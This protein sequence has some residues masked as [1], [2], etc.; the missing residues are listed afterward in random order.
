[1]V[2]NMNSPKITVFMA[3][4]NAEAFIAEAIS[5]ILNQSFEDFE[6][7]IVNDGSTDKT[8]E[9]IFSFTDSR[10]RLIHNQKNKGLAYTRNRALEEAQGE[11]IAVLDSD[12]IAVPDRLRLQYD[13]MAQHPDIAL[14]GGHAT[15]IDDQGQLTGQRFIVPTGNAV[16]M[17]MFFGNPFINSAAMFKTADLKEFDGYREFVPAEDFDFFLRVSEKYP[18]ANMDRLLVYYR[19]HDQNIS[20]IQSARLRQVGTNILKDMYIRWGI[21][22][23]ERSLDQHYLLFEKNYPSISLAQVLS[24]MSTLKRANRKSGRFPIKGFDAFLF[25]KWYEIIM[26]KKPGKAA[27][28]LLFNKEL[29]APSFLTFKQF[30][31]VFKQT[32]WALLGKK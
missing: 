16:G 24:V 30:R 8:V 11:F 13:Y 3:A 27:L 31:R 14:C 25:K 29:F 18:V 21:P 12:D 23:D 6:L 10:V 4:Y 7:L 19:V 9:V 32:F 26:I 5:S 20:T 15:L 17:E 1:M 2:E 22:V 28:P